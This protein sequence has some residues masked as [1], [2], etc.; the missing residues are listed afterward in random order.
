MP[1]ALPARSQG[2]LD[3]ARRRQPRAGRKRWPERAAGT[4]AA[5]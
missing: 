2:R 4:G 5:L 3:A 1:G